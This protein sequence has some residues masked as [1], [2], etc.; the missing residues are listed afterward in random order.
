ML[1]VMGPLLAESSSGLHLRHVIELPAPL[2]WALV[3]AP[4]VAALE[5]LSSANSAKDF[6][7]WVVERWET[8]QKKGQGCKGCARGRGK[9][10]N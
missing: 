7:G 8:G 2:R 5:R 9:G 10:I 1:M 3:S 6:K 4:F